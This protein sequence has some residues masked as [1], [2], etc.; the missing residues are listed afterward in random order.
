VFT[1]FIS[2]AGFTTQAQ[3]T[4]AKDTTYRPYFGTYTKKYFSMVVGYN[5]ARYQY[6][7]FGF[8]VNEFGIVGHHPMSWAL[9]AT[10][11]I[12]I[13]QETVVAPKLGACVAGGSAL[14]FNLLYYTNLENQG[15]FC[16]R[17]EIGVGFGPARVTYG[18]NFDFTNKEFPYM[19]KH[20][21][22]VVFMVPMKM[23]KFVD[24]M[25]GR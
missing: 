2:L 5:G 23:L 25:P 15:R 4:L 3:D 6:A 19:N 12:H 18:Y 14:V 8:A 24:T 11:E 21:L 20:C 7:E 22:N 1:L 10:T 13:G 17:P 9:Y 16:F